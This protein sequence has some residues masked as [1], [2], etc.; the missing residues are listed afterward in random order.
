MWNSPRQRINVWMY[1]GQPSQGMQGWMGGRVDWCE[2]TC[3]IHEQWTHGN[4]LT[5]IKYRRLLWT[6]TESSDMWCK[7]QLNVCV[8]GLH[9][10]SISGPVTFVCNFRFCTADMP[11]ICRH[12]QILI[13]N[14]VASPS[15][16]PKQTQK[17]VASSTATVSNPSCVTSR[18]FVTLRHFT[19][20]KIMDY[21]LITLLSRFKTQIRP[22]ICRLSTAWWFRWH[23][24]SVLLGMWY[25]YLAVTTLFGQKPDQ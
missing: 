12:L 16:K 11:S 7:M 6:N 15:C 17:I 25:K 4:D 18:Y 14:T 5:R 3:E 24:R 9:V 20:K 1:P 2:K 13:K 10:S 8:S 22:L 21:V 23:V 19:D